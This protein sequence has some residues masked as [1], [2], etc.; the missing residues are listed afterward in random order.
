MGKLQYF[1]TDL[2]GETTKR[3]ARSVYGNVG[4]FH[5]KAESV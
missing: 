5:R 3:Y 2:N 1:A 4:N